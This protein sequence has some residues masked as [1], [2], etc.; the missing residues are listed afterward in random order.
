MKTCIHNHSQF[1][2][3]TENIPDH[4]SRRFGCCPSEMAVSK[5][6]KK[7]VSG[8]QPEHG[9]R[10]TKPFL[11][12]PSCPFIIPW[13]R[14]PRQAWKRA[15]Y[16]KPMYIDEKEK[17]TMKLA[18]NSNLTLKDLHNYTES[19]IEPVMERNL[20]IA[21]NV[22]PHG[23]AVIMSLDTLNRILEDYHVDVLKYIGK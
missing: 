10:K 14:P 11:K 5:V 17:T 22:P 9:K 4:R 23:Q 7:A 20:F 3:E 18:V 2:Y 16:H 1:F 12:S 21:V 8:R 13:R 6:S 19:L 15:G